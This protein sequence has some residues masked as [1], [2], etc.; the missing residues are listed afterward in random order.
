[1]SIGYFFF[2]KHVCLQNGAKQEFCTKTSA[3]QKF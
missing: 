3:S 2:F 1:M